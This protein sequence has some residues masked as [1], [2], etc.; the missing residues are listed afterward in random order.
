MAISA[1]RS[2][3][4]VITEQDFKRA[5]ALMERAEV[6]MQEAF[7]QVGLSD[8]AE[9]T[10][11]VMKWIKDKGQCTRAEVMQ[12]FYRD[13][14]GRAMEIIQT[15]LQTARFIKVDLGAGQPVYTWIE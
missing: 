14:D 9:Q 10:T 15:T 8:Y 13:V 4:L 3:S 1:A 6:N 11:K 7:E 12:E 2:N 5:R